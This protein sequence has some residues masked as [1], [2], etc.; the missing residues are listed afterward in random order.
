MPRLPREI[1]DIIIDFVKPV[2]FQ[3]KAMANSK[4]CFIEES[5]TNLLWRSMSKDDRWFE[6]ATELEAEP[7]LIGTNLG[8]VITSKIGEEKACLYRLVTK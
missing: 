1:L 7:V 4:L 5:S 3:A 8:D 6:K 2:P